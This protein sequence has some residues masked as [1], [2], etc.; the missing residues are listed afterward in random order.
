MRQHYKFPLLVWLTSVLI[1]P[2]LTLILFKFSTRGEFSFSTGYWKL[3]LPAVLVGGVVSAP[4]FFVLWFCYDVLLKRN[5]PV[6]LI[7][8]VLLLVSLL[9]CVSL[10]TL[11][12]LVGYT[13]FWS[14]DSFSLIAAY[15]LPLIVGVLL[16]K[17]EEE[18]VII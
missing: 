17:V 11:V 5:E 7:R 8:L 2:K 16:F 9:C 18:Q 6:W 3:Y 12:S 4:C 13:K 14:G 1:G 15:S 10:F